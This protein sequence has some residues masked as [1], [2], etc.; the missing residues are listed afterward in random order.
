MNVGILL[1]ILLFIPKAKTTDIF[2]FFVLALVLW[3]VEDT[4]VRVC[5]TAETARLW[6]R[7]L[8]IGWAGFAP[9]AFHFA[10]RYTSL[11]SFYNRFG[12]VCIYL[13]FVV[14]YLLYMS[15]SIPS[16]FVH[17]NG[18]GWVSTPRAG[19][20]DGVQRLF[21]S[22]YIIAAVLILF[23][24]A[25]QIR[26][27]KRRRIQAFLIAA[28]MLIPTVQGITTQII[29]P[30]ILHKPEIP[31][32]SSF[33]T[34]F[35]LA[36]ILSIRK[37]KLFN[38]SESVE[39]ET[40]LDHL[41]NIV[42]VVSPKQQIIYMNPYAHRIFG[43]DKRDDEVINIDTI[44]PS[45]SQFE[46]FAADVF[47]VTFIGGA[48]RNYTTAFQTRSGQKIDV[49]LSAELITSNKQIQG[50]LLVANDITELLKTINELEISNN[51]L[52][53]FAH[54]ASHDLQ[55]PLRK[56]SNFLQLLEAKY[57]DKIDETANAY[58]NS[59]VNGARQMRKLIQDLLEY[60][61]VTAA[62][63]HLEPTDM[64]EVVEKVMKTLEWQIEEAQAD[65]EFDEL[66]VLHANKTQMIQLMQNLVSNALKY[67]SEKNPQVKLHVY[68]KG[69]YWQFSVN[70]NGIGID[71][72]FRE[73]VFVI[74]QRL[75]NKNEYP[76]SGVGLSICKK[77][78]EQHGGRIWVES[79]P[80][81]GSTFY[82]TI[83]KSQPKVIS[84][85]TEK[86]AADMFQ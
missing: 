65:V 43:I 74:F 72:K 73:H 14:F 29:Y 58:I 13:P 19:T 31:V 75:H 2:S 4:I 37:Y 49:L 26:K 28:G 9:I 85:S 17:H 40:V 54:V 10:C 39:I 1:Y 34:F 11:K 8:C 47:K 81:Q 79:Q 55:E 36:T 12:L 60:S 64:N 48:V 16:V 61:H 68:D 6:D 69:D 50:L 45:R 25:F 44:F 67:R 82:F 22:V 63:D 59:A 80:G 62:K 53:R 27:N 38:I 66:P 46:A 21:I 23:R 71:P 70:D 20:T 56:V 18:W 30:V 35:S 86:N 41:K 51:E 77:I 83:S 42:F 78:V 5:A 76:G 33:M 57:K 84:G 15:S 24:Y 3:Q 7:I 32:T 52:E